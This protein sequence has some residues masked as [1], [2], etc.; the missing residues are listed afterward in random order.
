MNHLDILSDTNVKTTC[1]TNKMKSSMMFRQKISPEN[2]N[3]TVKKDSLD[4]KKIIKFLCIS[5]IKLFIKNDVSLKNL[6]LSINSCHFLFGICEIILNHPN[7][8]SRIENFKLMVMDQPNF[9][10]LQPFLTSLPSLSSLIKHFNPIYSH[11]FYGGML[12]KNIAN[13][14][15]SQTQLSSLSFGCVIADTYL[16]NTFRYCFNTLTSIEFLHCKFSDV[17]SFNVLTLL[18]KL[19]SLQ[20][21]HCQGI[22]AQFFQPLLDTPTPL[23]IKTL[24]VSGPISGIALL[25]QK[26]GPYLK[27]LELAIHEENTLKCIMN[28]CETIKFL[29]LSIGDP[30]L[31]QLY[32][33]IIHLKHHLK[34]LSLDNSNPWYVWFN[35]FNYFKFKNLE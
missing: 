19:Q 33:L 5:L 10:L 32:E 17:L 28:S 27:H 22:T 25:L 3:L 13:I 12:P 35:W 7:L 34:Y 14:I 4:S 8:I 16:L 9:D 15:Q 2:K 6:N 20:F 30:N 29:S 24:R 31:L 21:I 23:K 11:I 26:V 18:T 1:S